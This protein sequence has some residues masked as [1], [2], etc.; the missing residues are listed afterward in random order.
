MYA[1]RLISSAFRHSCSFDIIIAEFTAGLNFMRSTSEIEQHCT[2]FLSILTKL[3]GPYAIASE[4]L[5][6]DWIK[7]SRAECGVELQLGT[8]LNYRNKRIMVALVKK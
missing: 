6:Q 7:D 3:G 1:A 5:Q 4:I 2:K 8:Y